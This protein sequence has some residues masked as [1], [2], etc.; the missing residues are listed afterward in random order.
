MLELKEAI[1]TYN[2]DTEIV[3]IVILKNDKVN[4]MTTKIGAK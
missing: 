1:T 4:I 3:F 2:Y